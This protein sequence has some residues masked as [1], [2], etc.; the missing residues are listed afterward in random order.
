M[1]FEPKEFDNVFY[2]PVHDFMIDDGE[3]TRL[4]EV[5][6]TDEHFKSL[7]NIVEVTTYI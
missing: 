1:N 6:T 5:I 7:L 3:L 4:L 2:E